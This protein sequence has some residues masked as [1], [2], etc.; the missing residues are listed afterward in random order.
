[1]RR[2]NA[3]ILFEAETIAEI[4]K[5][6]QE[7]IQWYGR[8]DLGNGNLVNLTNG[9]RGCHN[10][11]VQ[12]SV[13]QSSQKIIKVESTRPKPLLKLKQI[14]IQK[15]RRKFIINAR[16]N[17]KSGFLKLLKI[18]RAARFIAWKLSSGTIQ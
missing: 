14:I 7:F 9:G 12:R 15:I 4:Y 8:K 3:E 13:G 17:Q 16:R 2:N 6:E 10:V 1:M 18:N 5:K 11:V